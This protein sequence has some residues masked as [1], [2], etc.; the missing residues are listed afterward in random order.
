MNNKAKIFEFLYK[1]S[2]DSYN[3]NQISRLLGISVGSTFKILKEFERLDYVT[4][5]RKNNALLYQINLSG[6]T[7]EIYKN[8]EEEENRQSKKKTKI[9][10]TIGIASNNPVTIKKLIERGVDVARIDI[11]N[12]NEKVAI[13]IIQNIRQASSGIPILIDANELKSNKHWIRFALKNDLD[14]VSISAKNAEDIQE[15][16]R[17][18]GYNNINQ[19]I[20]EKIK[21]IAKID[22][23]S[24]K[25]YKEITEESYGVIID[26]SKLVSDAK[27]EMLPKLQKEVVDECNRYGKPAIIAGNILN[28]M[29]WNK[30]PLQSEVYDISNAVLEGASCLMLS[31]ETAN[32][33]YPIETA[34]TLSRIIK[35]AD[36]GQVESIT[37]NVNYDLTR[38][39]GNAVSELE[40]TLRID[41]LLIIT[42]GGY[43][44][45]M[46]SSRKLRCKTIAAT[47]S[48][49]IFR[50]LNLLWGI[51]PLQVNINSEN[52][53]NN[54]KKEVILKA[55][56]R[57]YIGKRSQIAVIASVFHSKSKRTNLLEIH[58]VNEFLEYLTKIREA[59]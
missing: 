53:S 56:E 8:L 46:I 29:I 55:I 9:M 27:I 34:E 57:G 49:K 5:N 13:N 18:L 23:G 33:R 51:E 20:G 39:I 22:K 58:N 37:Y 40:K 41:A 35:N 25:N 31:E 43:S 48:R 11:F 14:F 26:R 42:S 6:K 50:Q 10:C 30:Q 1:K 19:V 3:I 7:K 38:F 44:A 28:S 2:A 12:L 54:E 4:A 45:R 17:L 36:L 21:V 15:V 32:G 16:N 52:I 59:N 24:L 47:S